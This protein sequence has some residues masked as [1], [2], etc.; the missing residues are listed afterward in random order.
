MNK[1]HDNT[2]NDVNPIFLSKTPE[3]NTKLGNPDVLTYKQARQSNDWHKFQIAQTEEVNNFCKNNIWQIVQKSKIPR[4]KKILRMVWSFRRKTNPFNI[5]Y[6]WRS[7]LCVDGS[8]QEE[9]VDFDTSYSPVVSWPTVR[10]CLTLRAIHG[11]KSR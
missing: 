10:F 7:R 8:R 6:R 11:W 2:I 5:V 1:L 3:P 4:G 9:G